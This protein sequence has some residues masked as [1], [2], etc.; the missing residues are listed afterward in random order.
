MGEARQL[1]P[2]QEQEASKLQ[3]LR[4]LAMEVDQ[5]LEGLIAQVEEQIIQEVPL[6]MEAILVQIP[7]MAQPLTELMVVELIRL[8]TRVV[9]QQ[10]IHL[11]LEAKTLLTRIQTTALQMATLTQL[12]IMGIILLQTIK[13]KIQILIQPMS[14]QTFNQMLRIKTI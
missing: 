3:I 5:T 10:V 13:I 7:I 11:D 14:F 6:G 8:T 12:Q 4:I 1:I 9:V 2:Q